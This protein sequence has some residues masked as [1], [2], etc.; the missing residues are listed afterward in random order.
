MSDLLL[1][2]ISIAVISALVVVVT[3][4]LRSRKM[5][6]QHPAGAFEFFTTLDRINCNDRN[7]KLKRVT[8]FL[9]EHQQAWFQIDTIDHD[10]KIIG[11]PVYEK[12]YIS[13]EDR[14]FSLI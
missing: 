6:Q 8:H 11:Q 10:G 3:R 5:N 14:V 2:S 1:A 7:G 13:L 4:H 12:A 9:D